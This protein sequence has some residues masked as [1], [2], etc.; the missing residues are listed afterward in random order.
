MRI[1]TI[2]ALI[3]VAFGAFNL[4]LI[5]VCSYDMLK[6]IFGPIAGIPS[7]I[8]YIIIGISGIWVLFTALPIFTN[9]R[10]YEEKICFYS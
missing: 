9:K 10:K 1:T 6:S 8:L 2:I 5:G 3:F 7:R 4:L